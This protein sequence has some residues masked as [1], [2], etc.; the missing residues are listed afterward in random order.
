M[1]TMQSP[2]RARIATTF[3]QALAYMSA[4]AKATQFEVRCIAIEAGLMTF[5]ASQSSDIVDYAMRPDMDNDS[6]M[7][8]VNAGDV[9]IGYIY[10]AGNVYYQL[11]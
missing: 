11:T 1:P 2:P 3:I 8:E 9:H 5:N 6:A 10:V 7:Y 4:M